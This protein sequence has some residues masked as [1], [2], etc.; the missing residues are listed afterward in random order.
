M[1][2]DYRVDLRDSDDA[3]P[4]LTVGALRAKLDAMPVGLAVAIEGCDCVGDAVD[5][6]EAL[7]GVLI[8]RGPR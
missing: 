3:A 5:V 4:A 1:S 7:G 6:V 2:D 8:K